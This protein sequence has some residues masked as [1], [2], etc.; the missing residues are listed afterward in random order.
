MKVKY[1][2]VCAVTLGDNSQVTRDGFIE[3]ELDNSVEEFT[4]EDINKIKLEFGKTLPNKTFKVRGIIK[5]INI[6]NQ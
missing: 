4:E 1:Y 3:V 2:V 6:S 5:L